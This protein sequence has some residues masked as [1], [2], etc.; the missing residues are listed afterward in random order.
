MRGMGEPQKQIGEDGL[1]VSVTPP[2]LP[3]VSGPMEIGN[4]HSQQT[5]EIGL[6]NRPV[7][8][9]AEAGAAHRRDA[10]ATAQTA[11]KRR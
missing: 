3:M 6:T 9:C 7:Q 1:G 8:D 10:S 5:S 11:R 4:R 2:V